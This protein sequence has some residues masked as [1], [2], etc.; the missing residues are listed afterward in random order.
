VFLLVT[1][2]V[3]VDGAHEYSSVDC[4]PVSDC[5][6]NSNPA[7]SSSA[8]V[9]DVLALS[10]KGID[11]GDPTGPIAYPRFSELE[12]AAVYFPRRVRMKPVLLLN[13]LAGRIN[14]PYGEVAVSRS[15]DDGFVS[16]DIPPLYR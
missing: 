11:T 16:G 8:P 12:I 3:V 1:D 10:I 4:E 2:V 13:V 14:A 6:I 15:V 7:P 5:T 9:F